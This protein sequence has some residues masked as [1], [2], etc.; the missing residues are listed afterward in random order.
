[1]VGVQR[2]RVCIAPMMDMALLSSSAAMKASQ[3]S[4]TGLVKIIL[5]IALLLL[6]IDPTFI[7]QRFGILDFR[8][9]IK[10]PADQFNIK[11]Q[12]K[13]IQQIRNLQSAIQ[14]FS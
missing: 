9:W 3:V 6:I 14:N 4:G 11:R 1:M 5:S 10:D 12:S 13:A 8:I 7:P 2:F